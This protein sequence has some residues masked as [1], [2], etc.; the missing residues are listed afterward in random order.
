MTRAGN[1]AQFF[2][3]E[4][5]SELAWGSVIFAHLVLAALIASKSVQNQLPLKTPK[6][7][8]VKT[9]T[10]HL[11][12]SQKFAQK[13]DAVQMK[14]AVKPPPSGPLVKAKAPSDAIKKAP[15][16]PAPAKKS[17]PVQPARQ[18]VAKQTNAIAQSAASHVKSGQAPKP[19]GKTASCQIEKKPALSAPSGRR[20]FDQ[21]RVQAQKSALALISNVGDRSSVTSSKAPSSPSSHS[22]ANPPQ[23]NELEDHYNAKLI[24]FLTRHLQLGEKSMA[25]VELIIDDDGTYLSHTIISCSS[26]RNRDDIDQ[27]LPELSFLPL[28]V[29][30]GQPQTFILNLKGE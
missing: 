10:L 17:I 5:L 30:S 29:K 11:P 2:N 1:F 16:L 13:G 21:K 14:A 23:G 20:S 24:A 12:A 6:S 28:D 4:K 22:G 15:S 7:I 26:M 18:A 9:I 27:K 25:K 8:G 3:G 19:K